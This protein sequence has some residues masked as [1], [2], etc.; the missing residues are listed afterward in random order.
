MRHILLV[1]VVTYYATTPHLGQPLRWGGTFDP[2]AEPWV[3]VD[4]SF[5]QPND[6]IAIWDG[7]TP[8]RFPAR[9]TGYLLNHCVQTGT[10][11]LPIAADVPEPFAWFYPALSTKARVVNESAARRA[12]AHLEYAP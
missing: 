12:L 4:E 7:N 2:N 9:D 10:Q 5:A 3:A 6:I 11:C 1:V 8:H